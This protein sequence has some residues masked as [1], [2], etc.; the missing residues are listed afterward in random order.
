[1]IEEGKAGYVLPLQVDMK[2]FTKAL[3]KMSRL[4]AEEKA[5][6]SDRA[7]RLATEKVEQAIKETGYRQIFR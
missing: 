6:M 2:E 4:S 1:M 7:D 5:G 3:E